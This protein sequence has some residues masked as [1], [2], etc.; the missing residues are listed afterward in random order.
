MLKFSKISESV[1]L[2][3]Q[4][5]DIFISFLDNG[6]KIKI[7]ES[8]GFYKINLKCENKFDRME[9]VRDLV[10]ADNRMSSLNLYCLA[11]D[12]IDFGSGRKYRSD[13]DIRYGPKSNTDKKSVNGWEEFKLYC[14]NVLGINGIYSDYIK[15]NT[16]TK[17]SWREKCPDGYEG[18]YIENRGELSFDDILKRYKGYEDFLKKYIDSDDRGDNNTIYR[19]DWD[20]IH[21]QGDWKD[22]VDK[23]T[24]KYYPIP[25]DDNGIEIVKTL[26]EMTKNDGYNF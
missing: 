18:F 1:D 5:K 2:S 17:I 10:E 4:I 6:F 9:S 22:R 24:P 25:F 8:H 12:I 3:S 21:K 20:L 19:V 13:I 7:S 15:V 11:S 16:F 23:T 14:E 26:I